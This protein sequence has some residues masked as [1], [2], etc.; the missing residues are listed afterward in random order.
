MELHESNFCNHRTNQRALPLPTPCKHGQFFWAPGKSWESFCQ[1]HNPFWVRLGI[2]SSL[3]ELGQ[4]SFVSRSQGCRNHSD[5]TV[6]AFPLCSPAWLCFSCRTSP[7]ISSAQAALPAAPAP[8]CSSCSCSDPQLPFLTF[9]ELLPP[10]AQSPS[11][12]WQWRQRLEQVSSPS[13][14]PSELTASP[15]ACRDSSSSV[16]GGRHCCGKATQWWPWL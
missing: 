7:D 5:L 2:P 4:M 6:Q 13:G 9:S 16:Q 10:R 3:V 14:C 15:P 8:P 11:G 1:I 12:S